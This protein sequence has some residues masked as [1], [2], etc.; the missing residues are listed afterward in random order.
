MLSFII[1]IVYVNCDFKIKYKTLNEIKIC[2]YE[3]IYF[4]YIK[5][6]S[7][8]SVLAIILKSNINVKCW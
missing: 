7:K 2:M 4:R 1:C 3:K 6:V 8:I 5:S